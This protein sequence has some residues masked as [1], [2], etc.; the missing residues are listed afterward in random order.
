ME[1]KAIEQ[2]WRRW[3]SPRLALGERFLTAPLLPMSWLYRSLTALRRLGYSRG[4]LRTEKLPVPVISIGNLVMGGSGKTPLV[5]LIAEHLSGLGRMPMVLSRGYGKVINLP[6]LVSDGMGGVLAT[7]SQCGE[8]AVMMA[9]KLPQAVIVVG[10]KRFRAAQLGLSIGADCVVLDDGFQ[11]L[12]LARDLNLVVV[13]TTNPF[14]RVF[15]KGR[16]RESYRALRYADAILLNASGTDGKWQETAEKLSASFTEIP[17]IPWQK[18]ESYLRALGGKEVRSPGEIKGARILLFSMVPSIA[19]MAEKLKKMGAVSVQ[20]MPFPDHHR[21][22]QSEVAFICAQTGKYDLVL[23]TEKDEAA[24]FARAESVAGVW[25]LSAK[26]K[27]IANEN[28]FWTKVDRVCR[29]KAGD[30]LKSSATG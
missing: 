4:M 12:S 16:A 5:M 13:E 8:E 7:P 1:F 22:L 10:T 11:H 18:E 21:Y 23:T 15:P 19:Q 30:F 17:I 20:A 3:S 27:F 25:V 9:R 28:I 14:P 6:I 2:I 29:T 24:L 26:V